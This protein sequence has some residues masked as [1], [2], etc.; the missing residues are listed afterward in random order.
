MSLRIA[1]SEREAMRGVA[2]CS[3]YTL[4]RCP[5]P[6]PASMGSSPTMRSER[7]YLP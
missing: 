2:S 1:P 7:K 4:V 5:G 6:R 3:T